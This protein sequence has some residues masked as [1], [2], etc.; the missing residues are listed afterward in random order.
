MNSKQ[1]RSMAVILCLALIGL[2]AG[3][4]YLLYQNGP[5]VRYLNFDSEITETAFTNGTNMKIVFDRPLAEN[6]YSDEISFDPTVNFSAQTDGQTIIVQFLENLQQET[7]YSLIIKPEIYDTKGQKMSSKSVKRFTTAQYEFAYIERNYGMGDDSV[8]QSEADEIILGDLN[9]TRN[10]IFSHP[11]I[12]SFKANGE[13]LLVVGVGE[14]SDEIYVVDINSREHKSVEM[15]FDSRV[16]KLEVSPRG[17]IGVFVLQPDF[18]SVGAEKYLELANKTYSVNLET[19]EIT[20]LVDQDNYPVK[21]YDVRL[22]LNG[23]YILS[24]NDRY[25]YQVHS[26]FNDYPPTPLGSFTSFRDYIDGDK[27]IIFRK[28]EDFVKYDIATGEIETIDFS[29]DEFI[30]DVAVFNENITPFIATYTAD[31]WR[32]KLFS[33]DSGTDEEI[34]WQFNSLDSNVRTFKPSYDGQLIAIAI[35]KTS[36]DQDNIGINAVCK[37]IKTEIFDIENQEIVETLSGFDLVWL[38]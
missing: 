38:P 28:G 7:E 36:C 13:Y 14:Y 15:P 1:F 25:I 16:Q 34:L 19:G 24:Q 5:R 2:V 20:E 29:S 32:A 6:D 31:S 10:T 18:D 8:L 27:K 30:Q 35:N 21:S 26:P 17:N 4:G 33:F 12:R 22:D 37:N 3:I 9:G 11:V 23:Q